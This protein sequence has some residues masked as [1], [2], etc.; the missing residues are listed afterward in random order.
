M[1]EDQAD[2]LIALVTSLQGDVVT[3]VSL[4]TVAVL[5]LSILWGCVVWRLVRLAADKKDFS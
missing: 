3:L 4:G 2:T 5:L 1:T